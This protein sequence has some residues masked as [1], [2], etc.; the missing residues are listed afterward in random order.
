MSKYQIKKRITGEIMYE[1][2]ANSFREFVEKN[3]ADL[4]KVDFSNADLS[5]DK[6]EIQKFQRFVFYKVNPDNSYDKETT[7]E[8]LLMVGIAQLQNLNS[9]FSC[10]END[11]ALM[12]ME[13]ALMWLNKRTEDR[14][15][16]GVEGKHIA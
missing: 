15:E 10:R 16:R 14:K 12:K 6:E 13:G 3:K 2:E 4:F 11:I 7:L 8:E 1:G 9:R 5:N